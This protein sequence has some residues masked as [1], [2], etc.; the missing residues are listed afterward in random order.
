MFA[1]AQTRLLTE[2]KIRHATD[3][4]LVAHLHATDATLITFL[5]TTVATL[6]ARLHATAWRKNLRN[7]NAKTFLRHLTNFGEDP[8]S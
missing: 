2:S 3:A 6:V 4:T 8:T 5:H 7:L 1:F